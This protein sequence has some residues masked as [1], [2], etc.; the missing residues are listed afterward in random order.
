MTAE[1]HSILQISEQNMLASKGKDQS[2]N[3]LCSGSV[4]FYF[5]GSG[6]SDPY[7]GFTEP[8][9]D[10]TRYKRKIDV[11]TTYN[12]QCVYMIF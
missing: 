5:Y 3:C 11:R 6:S 2:N 7:Q 9:L 1:L 10:A 8:E 12:F 4:R